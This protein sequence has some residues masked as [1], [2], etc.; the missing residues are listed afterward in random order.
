MKSSRVMLGNRYRLIAS[1]VPDIHVLKSAK[2]TQ[3]TWFT[4]AIHSNQPMGQSLHLFS[5][6]FVC[7]STPSTLVH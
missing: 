2:V 7:F 5:P 3:R 4:G 1:M 6:L